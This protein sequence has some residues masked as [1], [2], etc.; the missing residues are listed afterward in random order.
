M[1]WAPILTIGSQILGFLKINLEHVKMPHYQVFQ[2]SST[3]PGSQKAK[4]EARAHILLLYSE[5]E[6]QRSTGRAKAGEKGK[7]GVAGWAVWS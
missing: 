1:H 5:L 7:E 6:S 2:S 4:P 3:W